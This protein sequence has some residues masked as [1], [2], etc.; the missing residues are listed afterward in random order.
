MAHL[1]IGV[2]N[3]IVGRLFSAL[4]LAKSTRS[5]GISPV[6]FLAVLGSVSTGVWLYTL[7]SAPYRISQMF[8]PDKGGHSDF[9]EVV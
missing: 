6:A 4:T 9:I 1:E 2:L 8:V 5:G 3:L 7:L